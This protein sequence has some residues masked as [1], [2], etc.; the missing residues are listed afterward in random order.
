MESGLGEIT[1]RAGHNETDILRRRERG[2]E[3]LRHPVPSSELPLRKPLSAA[4][5]GDQH[6]DLGPHASLAGRNERWCKPAGLRCPSSQAHQRNIPPVTTVG[7]LVCSSLQK[8]AWV[9]R[10]L[11]GQHMGAGVQSK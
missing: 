1:N 4:E 9:L 5:E 8:A 6:C 7:L 3:A 2:T 10:M 11:G